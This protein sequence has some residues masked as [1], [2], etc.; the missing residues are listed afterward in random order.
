MLHMKT[1]PE[2]EEPPSPE[3]SGHLSSPPTK[4]RATHTP[5]RNGPYNAPLPDEQE[6]S[7]GSLIGWLKSIVRGTSKDPEADL[8]E[9]LED[10][11]E[12]EDTHNGA[13]ERQSAIRSQE[14]LLISNILELRDLTVEDVMI[15]RVDICSIDADISQDRLFELLSEKQ[16]S[17]FPVYS[18]TLDNVLGTVH[19]KDIIAALAKRQTINVRELAREVPIIAPSM[20][21]LDLLLMMKQ[22]RRHMALVID[23]YGGIDGLVTIGDV[24]EAILG[25]VDDEYDLAEDPKLT[26][27]GAGVLA[28]GRVDIDVFEERYGKILSET[29][30][31]DNDTLGGL[32]F[33]LAG[34]V[35]ARG[36]IV[37]HPSGM[38]FE[39]LDADMRR[40]NRVL[41]KNIQALSKNN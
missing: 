18:E 28:D 14:R 31:E 39:I 17:R 33:A 13:D 30:R 21:V 10:Y 27:V 40:V 1:L 38:M 4:E 11:I 32:V 22:R 7:G 8:R 6:E 12:H 15:P 9:A 41:I 2:S 26:E 37:T 23:E 20:L 24:I 36:E 35:P 25:E 34:R 5:P 29:E 3:D 19:I 16:F